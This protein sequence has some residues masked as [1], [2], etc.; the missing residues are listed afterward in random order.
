[1]TVATHPVLDNSKVYCLQLLI[2]KPHTAKQIALKRW[3][4]T[5]QVNKKEL[6]VMKHLSALVK[7]GYARVLL[8]ELPYSYTITACGY[9][10]L[11]RMKL[12]PV[13]TLKLHR[14]T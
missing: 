12:L 1:M 8:M 3:P 5:K 2:L 9:D 4:E 6:T 11:K 13:T 10:E 7:A 14:P